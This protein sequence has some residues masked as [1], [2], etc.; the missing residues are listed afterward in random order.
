MFLKK[1]NQHFDNNY[2]IGN[3]DFKFIFACLIF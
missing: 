3:S 1:I 2:M